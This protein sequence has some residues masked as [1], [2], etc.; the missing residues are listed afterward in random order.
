[1]G[2]GVSVWKNRNIVDSFI[3]LA[4]D[5]NTFYSFTKI[6]HVTYIVLFPFSL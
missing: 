6:N 2:R 3:A 5:L 4:T 1:M